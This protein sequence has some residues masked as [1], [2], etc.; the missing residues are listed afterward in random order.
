MPKFQG[1]LGADSSSR[2]TAGST[3]SPGRVDVPQTGHQ[4]R[5]SPQSTWQS[6]ETQGRLKIHN[7]LFHW[8]FS[9]PS[10]GQS[11]AGSA[12]NSVFNSCLPPDK[13]LL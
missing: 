2:G 12:H 6:G 4:E 7:L 10:T 1:R 5:P 9:P 8:A 3:G 11:Q 13:Q